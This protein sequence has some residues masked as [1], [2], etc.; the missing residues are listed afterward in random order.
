L[1]SKMPIAGFED[2]ESHRTPFASAGPTF[3]FAI[4]NKRFVPH[5][6]TGG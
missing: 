1:T 5:L 3:A 2:R 4:V 6:R